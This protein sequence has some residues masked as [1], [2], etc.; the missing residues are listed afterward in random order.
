MSGRRQKKKSLRAYPK[1]LENRRRQNLFGGLDLRGA[2]HR[3]CLSGLSAAGNKQ[4]LAAATGNH[5]AAQ[6]QEGEGT[7]GG[8][9]LSSDTGGGGVEGHA[10]E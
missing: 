2:I 8:D 10:E 6:A 9:N 3:L 1:A 4:N 5:Q 7:G